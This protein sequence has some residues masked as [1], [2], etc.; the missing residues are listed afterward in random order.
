MPA[1]DYNFSIDKGASFYISFDY[2]DSSESV[3]NLTNWKA[4][5]SIKPSN[6]DSVITYFT[7]TTN[8]SYSFTIIPELGKIILRLPLSTI[9]NFSF[10]NAVYDLDLKAP[11]ELYLG[12]GQQ[13]IKLLKGSISIVS[14][15]IPNPE[16][17]DEYLWQVQY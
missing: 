2:R 11:N 12:A 6:S 5:L 10:T 1:P 7:D 9:D 4:R 3:I 14:G 8:S 16:P 13:I 17:F 15:N